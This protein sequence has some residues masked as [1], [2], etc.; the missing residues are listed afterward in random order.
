MDEIQNSNTIEQIPIQQPDT[1]SA[2]HRAHEQLIAS[3]N[4][5]IRKKTPINTAQF[6]TY[7]PISGVYMP[8]TDNERQQ[9]MDTIANSAPSILNLLFRK[10]WVT[11]A[12][13]VVAIIPQILVATGV[14]LGIWSGIVSAIA[15]GVGLIFS[16]SATVKNNA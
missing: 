7:N 1:R 3:M 8:T 9:A 15:G 10:H 16:Q 6:I 14:E 5:D 2:L 11:S 12:L 4:D 13:G